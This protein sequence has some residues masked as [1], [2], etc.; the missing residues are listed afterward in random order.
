[1]NNNHIGE[2]KVKSERIMQLNHNMAQRIM[3]NDVESYNPKL[4]ARRLMR[5]QGQLDI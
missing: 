5:S 1:M 4:Y 3:D 2:L